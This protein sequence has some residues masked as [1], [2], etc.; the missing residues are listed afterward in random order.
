MN[1]L[2]LSPSHYPVPYPS[3]HYNWSTLWLRGCDLHKHNT[4]VLAVIVQISTVYIKLYQAI[5]SNSSTSVND[6]CIFKTTSY[7]LH[8]TNVTAQ[9]F[10]SEKKTAEGWLPVVIV[11]WWA[12]GQK[13]CAVRGV[14][15]EEERERRGVGV[16]RVRGH[17]I[18]CILRWRNRHCCACVEVE[19][20]CEILCV[21]VCVCVCV[22]VC[23]CR[24]QCVCVCV[25]VCE[26]IHT[27]PNT[28]PPPPPLDGSSQQPPTL[29]S[30]L[31]SCTWPANRSEF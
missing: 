3:P 18:S 21:C 17:A 26:S 8:Q 10:L 29:S 4:T 22:S 27:G 31:L 25:C 16:G 20:R 28:P 14:G 9:P 24:L 12:G 19:K 23:V 1:F 15:V 6:K 2:T 5:Y 13:V 30:F 11:Q 7:P